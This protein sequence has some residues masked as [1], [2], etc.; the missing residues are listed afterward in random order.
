[1]SETPDTVTIG[2]DEYLELVESDLLLNQ[3]LDAGVDNWTGYDHID[4]AAIRAGVAA[5]KAKLGGGA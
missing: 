4:R 3:L 2:A 1:M 5:A